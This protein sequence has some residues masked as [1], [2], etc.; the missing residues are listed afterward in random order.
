VRDVNGSSDVLDVSGDHGEVLQKGGT[1]IVLWGEKG[2]GEMRWGWVGVLLVLWLSACGRTPTPA[3]TP[4]PTP[5]G[6]GLDDEAAI[7]AVLDAEAEGV[8]R[9]DIDLLMRL[10]AEDGEVRDA[11]H[12]PDDPSDD[13]VWQGRDAI[14]QRYVH[15][16][17]PGNPQQV[18][19]PDLEIRIE[20]TY[21]VVTSTTLIGDEIAPG[22]D[23]WEL[24]KQDGYWL[25][26]RL[27]YNLE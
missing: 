8:L 19:H 24:I 17:F 13:A 6:Y 11:N 14:Y 3:P 2:G 12:T 1:V 18:A 26:Y 15:L 7:R 27:I 16:V 20:G 4:T 10:W 22:G 5:I 9:Q 21:A 25:I 23:R